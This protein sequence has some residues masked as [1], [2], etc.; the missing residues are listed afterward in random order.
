MKKWA[1]ATN[2][3]LD[4][5]VSNLT[6]FIFVLLLTYLLQGLSGLYFAYSERLMMADN[7]KLNEKI[8]INYLSEDSAIGRSSPD[9]SKYRNDVMAIEGIKEYQPVSTFGVFAPIDATETVF[10]LDPMTDDTAKALRYNLVEGSWP[11]E[12]NEVVLTAYA[13]KYVQIGDEISS[14]LSII[15]TDLSV[16]SE[17][18]NIKIVGFAD[19]NSLIFNFDTMSEFPSL[20]DVTMTLSEIAAEWNSVENRE[21]HGFILAPM[22]S[23]GQPIGTSLRMAKYMVS[24]EANANHEAVEREIE[25]IFGGRRVHLGIDM[26]DKYKRDHRDEF[27]MIVRFSVLL[28]VL[29]VTGLFASVFL[30]LNKRKNEMATYFICGSTWRKSIL[31][32]C[33][34]YYPII[35]LASLAGSALYYAL[36][37][38]MPSIN[39]WVTG[40]IMIG[41]LALCT[42][43]IIPLYFTAP[44]MSPIEHIRKD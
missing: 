41:V 29:T 7:I 43:E 9:L 35:I 33:G 36:T 14:E 13:K 44:R 18:A 16:T 5:I 42:I 34:T 3:I 32:F 30:Q 1:L 27:L 39:G 8:F 11:D 25:L 24:L 19:T 40:M 6:I 15:N 28:S 10:R 23:S 4:N 17:H 37:K 26:I 2:I 38:P 21:M 20:Q 12:P 22:S 31:M